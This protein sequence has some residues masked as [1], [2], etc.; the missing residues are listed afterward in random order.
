MVVFVCIPVFRFGF[1]TCMIRFDV[2]S[3]LT[4]GVN[5]SVNSCLCNPGTVNARGVKLIFIGGDMSYTVPPLKGLCSC[6]YSINTLI[7]TLTH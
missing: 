5:V 3:K 4:I 1:N 7:N 6:N 2:H